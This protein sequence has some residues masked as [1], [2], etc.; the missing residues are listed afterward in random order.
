M[1]SGSN[2]ENWL[3]IYEVLDGG[4]GRV[5]S[6]RLVC[7]VDRLQSLVKPAKAGV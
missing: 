3:A 6:G 2:Q 7:V 1:S 4:E 5:S